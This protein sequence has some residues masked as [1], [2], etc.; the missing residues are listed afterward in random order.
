[1]T[2]DRTEISVFGFANGA[3][4]QV[5][6]RPNS[7][8]PDQV[9]PSSEFIA[10]FIVSEV[11]YY[12]VPDVAFDYTVQTPDGSTADGSVV[13]D[14]PLGV[15]P[16]VVRL[17]VRNPDATIE[18]DRAVFSVETLNGPA[19]TDILVELTIVDQLTYFG[20]TDED[21]NRTGVAFNGDRA[22]SA[23][24]TDDQS[25]NDD[26]AGNGTI[27]VLIRAGSNSGEASILINADGL[28]NIEENEFLHATISDITK[29]EGKQVLVHDD[30]GVVRII[31][32]ARSFE[33][34]ELDLSLTPAPITFDPLPDEPAF[35]T[36]AA[37]G[38][39]LFWRRIDVDNNLVNT[40]VLTPGTIDAVFSEE[41]RQ[42]IE[43]GT[44][45]NQDPRTEQ[46][47]TFRFSSDPEWGQI[48]NGGIAPIE[49][50]D[51]SIAPATLL[52]SFTSRGSAYWAV[53]RDDEL[54]ELFTANPGLYQ[55]VG[56]ANATFDSLQDWQSRGSLQI[57]A[58]DEAGAT[59]S[60]SFTFTPATDT[61]PA[62]T[63][64]G[65]DGG[66]GDADANLISSGATP[67]TSETL[68]ISFTGASDLV[69]AQLD[70]DE[71][72]TSAA[73]ENGL[74][75]IAEVTL[76]QD[77]VERATYLVGDAV[78]S[79]RPAFALDTGR[80]TSVGDDRFDPR[81]IEVGADGVFVVGGLQ[82]DE[83]QLSS[84]GFSDANPFDDI[85]NPV[86][87][88]DERAGFP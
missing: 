21:G 57:T 2:F 37:F 68:T 88:G 42:T 72:A 29:T 6:E 53:S 5:I 35:L 46:N 49:T 75:E 47:I 60:T 11:E 9:I 66:T 78:N 34:Q 81:W 80:F 27:T 19:D 4:T 22:N 24:W 74:Y 87:S 15:E 76:L 48:F 33:V 77:G 16:D 71:F 85:D 20:G 86:A 26:A 54:P 32:A 1:M 10:S 51:G 31:D 40:T 67:G 18:G 13:I 58:S 61:E 41:I 23:D 73:P 17:Q 43:D 82:F 59:L 8:D 64:I 28:A 56:G 14:P 69:C 12:T 38:E 52:T 70:L 83:I 3:R 65:V 30:S 7:Q 45:S 44:P 84:F 36:D 25:L 62:S 63:Q 50:Q 39:V 55:E 79:G